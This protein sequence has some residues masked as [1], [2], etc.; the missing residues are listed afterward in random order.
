MGFPKFVIKDTSDGQ[1]MFNLHS[2]GN[3]EIIATSERYTTKI[4]CLNGVAAVK[5]DAADAEIDD[6]T[7]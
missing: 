4:A 7:N 3:G 5:R 1:F 6:Q 2:K